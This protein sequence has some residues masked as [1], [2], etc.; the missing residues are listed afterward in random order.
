[1]RP[2][3]REP[4][5]RAF[6]LAL[7]LVSACGF[8]PGDAATPIE[9][10]RAVDSAATEPSGSGLASAPEVKL[11]D[12]WPE[13]R[14]PAGSHRWYRAEL[15][16]PRVPRES[17]GVFLPRV[18]MNAGVWVND[19]WLGAGGRLDPPPARNWNRPL[20]FH[21]PAGLLHAGA[22]R[23]DLRLA[24]EPGSVGYLAPLWVG[25]YDALEPAFEA[26]TFAQVTIVEWG[27]VLMLAIGALIAVIFFRRPDL[28]LFGWFA[29]ATALWAIGSSELFV[30]DTPLPPRAWQWTIAMALLGTPICFVFQAH[31]FFEMTRPRVERA[32]ATAAG[33]AALL[34][35]LVPPQGFPAARTAVVVAA[36]VVCAYLVLVLLRG[37]RRDGPLR[38]RLLFLPAMV[39][40]VFAVHDLVLLFT[41][42]AF[43]PFFLGPYLAPMV[44]LWG[45]W[46]LVDRFANVLGEVESLNRDLERRVAEKAA[47]LEDNYRRM[48]RL[49][50]ERAVRDERERIMRDVHEGLGG[51][52][53]SLLATVESRVFEPE[54]LGDAI[55]DALDDLRILVLSRDEEDED[56]VAR[57]S[58]VR[59]RLEPR[60]R[61]AGLRFDWQIEDVPSLPGGGSHPAL[62]V[63][64]LVHEAIVNAVRHAHAETVTVRT[65]LDVRG[66][67]SGI[68]V[69][70]RDDGRGI[71]PDQ[72]PGRGIGQM[73]RRAEA[74]GGILAISGSP[75]GTRV[76]LWIP[77]PSRRASE[78]AGM[79]A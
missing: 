20:L 72:A 38:S 49:E 48:Q 30:R 79:T 22:N 60:L 4:L 56:L 26:R 46:A 70:V 62:H 34:L 39:G 59:G 63:Q 19:V 7:A 64:R 47:E 2:V 78:P 28:T 14:L 67:R 37:S 18:V 50:T 45:G 40:I 32:L 9:R 25:P 73:R 68:V 5:L 10:V 12:R 57:L 71:A 58:V 76:V 33:A 15:E 1:M 23:I 66:D 36:A 21:V 42:R 8:E 69:E 74:V 61:R 44:A 53:M 13:R 35:A 55:R 29:A 6:A 43:P 65:G 24:V 3:R 54:L 27:V 31:R 16:L 41:Q 75:A 52:L 51:Q 17:F 77:L 11:P